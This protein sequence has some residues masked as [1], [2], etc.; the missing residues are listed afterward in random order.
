[1]F[2]NNVFIFKCGFTERHI[3]REAGFRW[4]TARK[5]WYTND[6]EVALGLRRYA[7]EKTKNLFN[8]FSITV[9]PWTSPLPQVPEGLTLLPH[10]NEAILFALA[11]NKSYLGLDPG[12]GKT[13]VAAL[14]VLALGSKTVYI[15][16]PFLVKN[17]TEEFS[18]FAP[19]LVIDTYTSSTK[20]LAP[21]VDVLLVP[22]SAL[23]R[24]NNTVALFLKRHF[25]SHTKPNTLIVDEAHR[26]KNETA[27]R[28]VALF[29]DKAREPLTKLFARQVYMSGTPMPNRPIE[30]YPVLSHAAPETID[31]MTKFQYA[32]R[33]CAAYVNDF[34]RWDFTG[35]SNME[36]L[37][38][39]VIYPTGSFML[40]LKKEL[41]NLPP[42]LEEVFVVS[43]E[44]TPR[45]A[46]LDK[47]LGEKYNDK[48]DIVKALLENQTGGDLHLMTY[49][50]LLGS[51]KVAPTVE[52]IKSLI[53]ETN[54]S[55][56]VFAYHADVISSLTSGLSEYRPYVITG[57]TPM[58]TRHE[59]VKDFE[60]SDR[61]IF[62]GNYLAM[63]TGF[64][65][66][67]ATRVIFCEFSWV[68][69]DNAQ[70][71]DRA[72]RI[73]QKG[74]VLVQY[75]VYK[76]SVDKL[77]IDTILRKRRAIEHI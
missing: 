34:G 73:G 35:A 61:R 28:T 51:E 16:P 30:L 19:S 69:G 1:M 29:G 62:I 75:V 66:T 57:D 32:R 67:K 26:A 5:S 70:A 42:K 10:Q 68:P 45:V 58:P 14:V 8:K 2:R 76:D 6:L 11:R 27:N 4:D 13:A 56:L 43:A 36:E 72:H 7:D 41:L 54:E 59:Q 52:Y 49:R 9:T 64:T 77:V 47:N 60:T 37:R 24:G 48:T 71:S 44:M 18:R 22:D 33:Y 21:D 46:A 17:V 20:S 25:L 23:S 55:I 15:T 31:F 12:L 63:G 38:R 65:M 3:P 53:E 40:R 74:T 39:R 50:R